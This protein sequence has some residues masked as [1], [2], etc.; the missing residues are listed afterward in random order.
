MKIH[1]TIKNEKGATVS[2][3]ANEKLYI[4]LTV[5]NK[6]VLWFQFEPKNIG[7][8]LSGKED[9]EKSD[10]MFLVRFNKERK[11]EEHSCDECEICH[12]CGIYKYECECN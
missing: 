8:Y 10:S 5:G 2:K 7:M 4:Y 9:I 6:Q 11:I 1:A 12:G 3:G